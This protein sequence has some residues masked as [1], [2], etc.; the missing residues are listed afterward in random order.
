MADRKYLAF[1]R[2]HPCCKCG[3]SPEC[4]QVEAH[5]RTGDG[6]GKGQKNPDRDTMPLCVLCHVAF[7]ALAGGFK[8]MVRAELEEWQESQV[9]YYRS[10]YVEA[11]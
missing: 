7:H 9:Q 1:I 5:H 6:K 8:G 4:V 3:A 10:L 11:A 2:S